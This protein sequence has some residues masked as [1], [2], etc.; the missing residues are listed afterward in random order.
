[1]FFVT[2]VSNIVNNKIT[3]SEETKIKITTMF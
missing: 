2:I 1:M 3:I